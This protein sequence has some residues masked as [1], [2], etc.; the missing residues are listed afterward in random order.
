M[1]RAL[2]PPG[3]TPDVGIPAALAANMTIGEQND[4]LRSYVKAR[5][6]SW[7]GSA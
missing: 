2:N 3:E 7:P 5:P 6:V 4:W 1:T